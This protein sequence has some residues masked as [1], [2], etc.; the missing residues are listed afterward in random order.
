MN[1]QEIDGRL[2]QIQDTGNGA[3]N[4]RVFPQRGE[5]NLRRIGTKCFYDIPYWNKQL[6]ACPGEPTPDHHFL[7]IEERGDVRGEDPKVSGCLFDQL[8]AVFIPEESCLEYLSG[9]DL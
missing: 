6:V 5:F 9:C 7:H 3:Q 4:R 2:P 1:L 8:L